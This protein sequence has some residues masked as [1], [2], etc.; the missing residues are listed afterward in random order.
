MV[1]M[2]A[3]CRIGICVA[4]ASG[5]GS[6]ADSARVILPVHEISVLVSDIVILHSRLK[7]VRT[8]PVLACG[9]PI[10]QPPPGGFYDNNSSRILC[11]RLQRTAG[12]RAHHRKSDD[13]AQRARPN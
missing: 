2:T 3:A 13:R 4:V 5:V 11:A 1:S 6:F 12:R 8:K 9:P 10:T 7:S